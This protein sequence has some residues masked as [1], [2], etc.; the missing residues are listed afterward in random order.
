MHDV[1]ENGGSSFHGVEEVVLVANDRDDLD[2]RLAPLGHHQRFARLLNLVHQG[3]AL[4]LKLSGGY[5]LH[6]DIVTWS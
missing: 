3:Q 1:P 5:F 4:I 2:H 6:M